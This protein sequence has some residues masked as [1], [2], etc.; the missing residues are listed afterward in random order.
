MNKTSRTDEPY[1]GEGHNQSPNAFSNDLTTNEDFNGIVNTRTQRD[2]DSRTVSDTGQSIAR[3]EPSASERD[4]MAKRGGARKLAGRG[5]ATGQSPG[6]VSSDPQVLDSSPRDN[7][8][9]SGLPV[10]S[11]SGGSPLQR[12]KHV[13]YTFSK[14]VGPGF[15]VSVAYSKLNLHVQL[16]SLLITLAG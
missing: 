14:F 6:S 8:P 5:G 11:G 4:E 7:S 12:V 15:L 9:P 3:A 2:S 10:A 1:E 13:L 16:I